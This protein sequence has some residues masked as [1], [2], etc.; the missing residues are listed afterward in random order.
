MPSGPH[1]A[2]RALQK[3]EAHH[4]RQM[5]KRATRKALDNPDS[6]ITSTPSHQTI[7]WAYYW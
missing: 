1:S 4:A 6:A 3:A 2:K 7:Y 5:G